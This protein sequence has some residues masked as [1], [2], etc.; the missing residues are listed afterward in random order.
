MNRG[1]TAA[2]LILM[3]V[4]SILLASGEGERGQEDLARKILLVASVDSITTW[5]PSASY[6]TEIA[7]FTNFYEGLIR[8]NPPGSAEPFA[9]L[10]A[11]GWEVSDDG[12]VWTFSLREGVKFHDGTDFNSEAVKYSFERTK[13][14]GLGAAFILDPIKEINIIDDFEVQ[15]RLSYAAPLDRIVASAYGSWI[16]SPSTRGMTREWFE[17]GRVAGTGPYL[18]DSYSP[19]QEIRLI[20][21]ENYWNYNDAAVEQVIIKIVKD[22]VTMQNMLE[23]GQADI[24]TL[25]PRESLDSV[26][27]RPDCKILRG[28]SFM[29]YSVHMNT[30]RPPLDNVLVRKAIS[31][32][33]PYEDIIK[34][35]VGDLGRQAAGPIPYGQ[36]GFYSDL[37]KYDYDV[38]KARELMKKAGYPDGIERELVFTYA[39]ENATHAAYAPLLAESLQ[40]IGISLD[41]RPMMWNAQWGM[42][43]GE[44]DSTQ[45]LG[46]LLWWPTINDPFETLSSLWRTEEVPF[47]NFSYYSNE[48]FDE[49]I[50]TA[51]AEP[52]DGRAVSMYERAQKILVEDAPALYLID[53]TTAVPMRANVDGYVINPSYPKAMYFHGVVK[54]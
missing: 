22:A 6:S 41:I 36:F 15:F 3:L 2:V 25:V 42:M 43:K 37:E 51:Y 17:Q 19:E 26:D 21:N 5:D 12:L 28:P 29:S 10:L 18:L 54:N 13:E 46:A 44:P 38:G 52:D 40:K 48:E 30:S 20:K 1:I 34:V 45:D 8:A 32:V 47:F 9:P 14:L 49:L 4:P 27:S 33:V 39:A 16:I 31:H 50:T 35:S 7:Y 23:S 53:L 11:T 24:V